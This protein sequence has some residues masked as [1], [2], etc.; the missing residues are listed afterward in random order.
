MRIPVGSPRLGLG[1]TV[2]RF[3]SVRGKAT[4]P[5]LLELGWIK[6]L[7]VAFVTIYVVIGALVPIAGLVMRSFTKIFTPLQNPLL[8]LTMPLP[9]KRRGTGRWSFSARWPCA[10]WPAA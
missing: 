7:A 1:A 10:R 3:V 6:W 9:C 2:K 4:R 5:R 8:S